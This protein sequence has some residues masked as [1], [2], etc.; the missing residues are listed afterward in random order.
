MQIGLLTLSFYLSGCNSLK[1]KRHRLS[2]VRDKIG[3]QVNV[4]VSEVGYQDLHQQAQWA[5]VVLANEKVLAE[6]IMTKIE[7]DISGS[8]DAQITHAQREFL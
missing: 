6:Q 5:F 1:E 8:Y 7:S 4:A 2:G 3:K